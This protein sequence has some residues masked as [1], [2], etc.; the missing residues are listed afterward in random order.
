MKWALLFAAVIF[1]ARAFGQSTSGVIT[2]VVTD[3]SGAVM[4]GAGISAHNTDTGFD[5][6]VTTTE[7]GNYTVPA[8]PTGTYELQITAAGFRTYERKGLLVQPANVVRIDVQMQV[9]TTTDTVTVTA[10]TPLP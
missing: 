8:L 2:V 4:A 9:G 5:Y 10:D 6:S 1:N 3:S 7:T